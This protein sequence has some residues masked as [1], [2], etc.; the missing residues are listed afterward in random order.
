MD[1][2]KRFQEAVKASEAMQ[3]EVKALG[4]D[5]TK[6]IAYANAKGF[7]FTYEDVKSLIVGDSE[8]SEED[9]DTVSGGSATIIA[10]AVV[11]VT[12][13]T[14]VLASGVASTIFIM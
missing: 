4:N 5:V 14:S 6:I 13:D 12:K 8:L 7:D 1:A 2:Y 10:G 3:S 9:L 11:D